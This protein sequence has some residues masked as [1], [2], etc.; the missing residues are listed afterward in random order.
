MSKKQGSKPRVMSS[1][2]DA[3]YGEE[4]LSFFAHSGDLR[5]GRH[6]GKSGVSVGAKTTGQG[7]ERR[8]QSQ[9]NARRRIRLTASKRLIMARDIVTDVDPR[10]VLSKGRLAAN[11]P[12][13]AY[14]RPPKIDT[15]GEFTANSLVLLLVAW[16][17]YYRQRREPDV[18]YGRARRIK[19]LGG[20]VMRTENSALD[21]VVGLV[22]KG[23]SIIRKG[24]KSK[25]ADER[26]VIAR[27]GAK[28]ESSWVREFLRTSDNIPVEFLPPPPGRLFS[29]EGLVPISGTGRTRF[30]SLLHSYNVVVDEGEFFIVGGANMVPV[31]TGGRPALEVRPVSG[32]QRRQNVRAAA[33][34][35][36][37]ETQVSHSDHVDILLSGDVEENPGPWGLTQPT[38]FK[39]LVKVLVASPEPK[40]WPYETFLSVILDRH[41][42]V[43]DVIWCRQAMKNMSKAERDTARRLLLISGIEANPGPWPCLNDPIIGLTVYDVILFLM[44]EPVPKTQAYELVLLH[45][46]HHDYRIQGNP[47][48]TALLPHLSFAERLVIRDLLLRAGIEP[49]PGP[50]KGV[51]RQNLRQAVVV[52]ANEAAEL[53]NV[54]AELA[55]AKRAVEDATKEN[56]E[57]RVR[58]K[59][60]CE[61]KELE[62]QTF[63]WCSVADDPFQVVCPLKRWVVGEL[64]YR[65]TV[66]WAA[67]SF[68]VMFVVKA[69]LEAVRRSRFAGV[70]NK[71]SY[72]ANF[73]RLIVIILGFIATAARVKF[74]RQ[75]KMSF[76]PLPVKPV[77]LP[78]KLFVEEFE[79][80]TVVVKKRPD[81]D[82]DERCGHQMVGSITSD[83]D[84][85]DL[86]W[87]TVLKRRFLFWTFSEQARYRYEAIR[88]NRRKIDEIYEGAVTLDRAE[89]NRLF[90]MAQRTYHVND[91]V[92]SD[93]TDTLPYL[94]Y[95]W[96]VTHTKHHDL[97]GPLN[98]PAGQSYH[99]DC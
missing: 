38:C 58:N 1:Y 28:P 72:R 11:E 76:I 43:D 87:T 22:L 49:N 46:L 62:D 97:I 50:P 63:T 82:E 17:R 79:E 80:N 37:R 33:A 65:L 84:M 86:T 45:L 96:A 54:R 26:D 40:T 9:R 67:N 27:Y 8:K 53:A 6:Y 81:S 16:M 20:H 4:D 30:A 13:V 36:A 34:S 14:P 42:E 24:K 99:G 12:G 88:F 91:T 73:W 41:L 64:T 56:K 7:Q 25:S 10:G 60:R 2:D 39:Q 90:K 95:R 48:V 57:L 44:R 59:K 29:K 18:H 51:N 66:Y 35:A 85:C 74:A 21:V 31:L 19:T 15:A 77:T 23:L 75:G 3:N 55:Q 94:A 78:E 70:F 68:V 5:S 47:E 83:M 93:V 98:R 89:I 71:M 69:M 61:V 52:A 92:G 32:K